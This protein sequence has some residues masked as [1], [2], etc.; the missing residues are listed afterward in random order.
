MRTRHRWIVRGFRHPAMATLEIGSYRLRV[1]AR[2]RAWLFRT[3]DG[4]LLW[5][6]A[7]VVDGVISDGR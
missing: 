1:V 3:L 4:S 5:P 6:D 7:W 2:L